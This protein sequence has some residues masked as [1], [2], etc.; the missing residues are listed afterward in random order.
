MSLAYREL[1][2]PG[3]EQAITNYCPD[4]ETAGVSSFVSYRLISLTFF[5]SL[6]VCSNLAVYGGAAYGQELTNLIL[7]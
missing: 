7:Y 5:T 4:S 1:I 6:T 3:G 2:E